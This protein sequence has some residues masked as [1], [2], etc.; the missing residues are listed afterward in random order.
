MTEQVASI[1][2]LTNA[3]SFNVKTYYR[4]KAY[5]ISLGKHRDIYINSFA[6]S[7]AEIWNDIPT[8]IRNSVSLESFKGAYLRKYFN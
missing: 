6:Y 1:L 4:L 2:T 5:Q 8:N 3:Q 7:G